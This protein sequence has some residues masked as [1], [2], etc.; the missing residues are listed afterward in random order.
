MS[1]GFTPTLESAQ[2]LADAPPATLGSFKVWTGS[3]WEYKPVK[4][5][6]GSVWEQ[7]SLKYWDGTQWVL[8]G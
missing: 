3:V 6:T 7:K 8:K 4:V 1:W 5:W 2:L